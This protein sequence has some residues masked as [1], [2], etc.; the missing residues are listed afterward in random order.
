MTELSHINKVLKKNKIKPLK[1]ITNIG[2]QYYRLVYED[3]KEKVIQGKKENI[4]FTK[5][6]V[7]ILI[8]A[9]DQAIEYGPLRDN[10]D[11][12]QD[13][14]EQ[15]KQLIRKNGRTESTLRKVVNVIIGDKLTKRGTDYHSTDVHGLALEF[16]YLTEV[17][18]FSNKKAIKI[19]TDIY[20]QKYRQKPD[21]KITESGLIQ[22]LH[23]FKKRSTMIKIGKLPSHDQYISKK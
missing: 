20:N 16:Q 4:A 15:G 1:K 22:I 14:I 9:L 3:L 21:K 5:D 23:E 8:K 12:L 17:K 11:Q 10:F 18:G 2:N 6:E 19:L 7:G 13:N